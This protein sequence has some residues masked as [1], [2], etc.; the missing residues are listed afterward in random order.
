MPKRYREG[1][2]QCQ[3]IVEGTGERCKLEALEDSGYCQIHDPRRRGEVLENIRD[4]R[5]LSAKAQKLLMSMEAEDIRATTMA[6]LMRIRR[7]M[8]EG[9]IPDALDEKL[10]VIKV[11]LQVVGVKSHGGDGEPA[12]ERE[13]VPDYIKEAVSE[14][15]N[16]GHTAD[17]DAEEVG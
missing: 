16:G 11:I 6:W 14:A 1:H 3:K 15:L 13:G 17:T 10:K 7:Q 9:S 5:E 4:A 2:G 8:M 12:G